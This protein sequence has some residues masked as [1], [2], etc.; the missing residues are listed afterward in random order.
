MARPRAAISI[1]CCRGW[2]LHCTE[3]LTVLVEGCRQGGNGGGGGGVDPGEALSFI[4]GTALLA[5]ALFLESLANSRRLHYVGW[6]KLLLLLLLLRVS[7]ISTLHGVRDPASKG[8]WLSCEFIMHYGK[9]IYP[10]LVNNK[11][12][13]RKSNM[14]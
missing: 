11:K 7:S 13:V 4:F 5:R 10:P 3:S 9:K 2:G 8:E 6:C 1:D 14:T 12:Q